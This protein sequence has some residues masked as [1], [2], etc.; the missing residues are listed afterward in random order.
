MAL[1]RPSVPY[2]KTTDFQEFQNVNPNNPLPAT[3]VDRELENV[4][5]TID[6]IRQRLQ[7]IQRDDGQVANRT[8]GIEQLKAELISGVNPPELWEPTTIYVQGDSVVTLSAWYFCEVDHLSSEEFN[9]DLTAGYWRVLIDLT[10]P[11]QDAIDAKIAAELAQSLAETAQTGAETARTG[12]ET[13]RT[14]AQLAETNANSSASAAST[15]ATNA[16]NSATASAN[17]ATASANS[18]TAAASSET[19]SAT[20]AINSANSATAAAATLTDFRDRY[21]GSYVAAPNTA[22]SGAA[23]QSGMLYLNKVDGDMYVYVYGT[24]WVTVSN[25]T[26]AINAANSA[27]ASANSATDSADSATASANSATASAN[28]A[29]ASNNSATASAASASNANNSANAAAGSASNALAS[30]NAA[31]A[32]YTNFDK[33]YLGQKA[34]APTVDNQGAALV[35]GALYFN[36]TVGDMYV[37]VYG[38]GWVTVSNTASSDAA[39]TSAIN[40]A[41]SATASANSATASANSATASANSASAA[42]TSETNAS[43][44]A[45]NAATSATTANTHRLSAEAARDLALG[46]KNSAEADALSAA[47]SATQ[48]AAI[49]LEDI[50]P[51]YELEV[52]TSAQPTLSSNFSRNKHERY[53]LYGN[54]PK[55]ILQQWDVDRNSTATYIDA[56]G[57]LQTA[58]PHQPRIDYSTGEGRLLVEGQGTNLLTWSEDFNQSWS[59]SQSTVSSDV[60]VAP[61]GSLSGDKYIPIA[62]ATGA[63]VLQRQVNQAGVACASLFVKPSE[64]F[65]IRIQISDFS[66]I[67]A[68]SFDVIQKSLIFTTRGG[69][70]SGIDAGVESFDHGW[71]RVWVSSSSENT[72]RQLRLFFTDASGNNQNIMGDGTSGIYIWGAQLEQAS[73]PSSYIPTQASQVTRLADIITPKGDA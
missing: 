64:F 40:A 17:S 60:V 29:T 37:Y 49:A 16:A 38:T 3:D 26:S 23:L 66:S 71:V 2:I 19:A 9:D 13:A 8:I 33:R 63:S 44:S 34:S 54:E 53:E 1:N 41:N 70:W 46:Y 18:A 50:T 20:T 14:G 51:R 28:S 24:G 32:T 67:L 10:I 7:M 56:N 68:A 21:L 6:E 27:T 5:L 47:Q 12:A 65:R 42:S 25:T 61:D 30:E 57:V 52:K 48:A 45:T 69:S 62:D 73:S 43:T 4:E 39:N 11:T 58:A 35:T 55:T 72:A 15:S 36:I 22:V 31:A 59:K